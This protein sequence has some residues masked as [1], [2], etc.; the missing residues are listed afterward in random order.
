LSAVFPQTIFETIMT[1]QHRAFSH[2]RRQYLA[3]ATAAIGATALPAWAQAYPS[4][5]VKLV[6]GAP[7][8]G[9]SDF[10]GRLMADQLGP[11]MGQPFVVENKPG[12]S[13][14]PAAEG[15]AKSP[16][17]GHTLLVSGPAS[18]AV[19][20]HMHKPGYDPMADFVPVCMLGAGSFVLVAH[21][22]VPANTVQELVQAA[23]AKP[24]DLTYGS[25]GNGSS[26]HL[27]TEYF[28][29][30]T[31]AKFAHIPYKGDGQA[32]LD[33]LSGQIKIMFTAPNVG[34][35]HVKSGKLKLLA[36]TSVERPAGIPNTPTVAESV[37]DFE[38]L[39][40]IVVFAPKSTP[41]EAVD[42]LSA[43]W[44]KARVT[45]AVRG[46]LDELAMAAPERYATRA[47]VADFVRAE[48][49]RL[50]KLIK[51]ANITAS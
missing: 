50:G 38:Y 18:I 47:A 20:P 46:K 43:A 21:P 1:T 45:P 23:K 48:H 29:T 8:G 39:G 15:V 40:W 41:R 7:P 28:S 6:V 35:P 4:K 5:P 24:G 12:A 26:G 11:A 9:P 37:K 16:A 13:G 42:A 25:G 36:T 33:L 30:L 51:D 14:M 2:A 31:G 49:A 10:L 32:I 17:D 27:C 34:M 44:N 3:A 22:S 19:A